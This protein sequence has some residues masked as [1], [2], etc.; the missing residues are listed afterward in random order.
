MTALHPQQLLTR[1]TRSI[2]R[3]GGETT[4]TFV[5]NHARK[6]CVDQAIPSDTAYGFRMLA[7]PRD[8]MSYGIYFFGEYDPRMS[9]LLT[10]FV[11]PG[12]TC[13]DI[14]AGLGW[15]TLLMASRV[16]ANGRVDAFEALPA[17]AARVR[18]NIQLNRYDCIRLHQLAV[19][20]KPG[21]IHFQPPVPDDPEV[22]APEHCSGI[23]YITKTASDQT[24]SIEATTLDLVAGR[25]GIEALHLI[26]MDIEGAEVAALRGAEQTLRRFKPIIAIEY[27]RAALRRSGSSLEQL[28]GLLDSFGYERLFFRA[29]GR[30]QRL[31]LRE[32][33]DKPDELAVFNVYAFHRDDPRLPTLG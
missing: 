10:R 6:W 25:E 4:R 13:W 15:F 24:L 11:E 22:P 32:C 33:A 1:V 16:G 29:S 21:T 14:G 28:D 17:N 12:Q 19:S 9:D 27:N 30:C 18:D 20:D 7:S 23:G 5:R 31:D 2:A 3:R 8:Y 26:K